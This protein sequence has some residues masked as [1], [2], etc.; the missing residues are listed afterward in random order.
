MVECKGERE[1]EREG[2]TEAES[3]RR[4]AI[5]PQFTMVFRRMKTACRATRVEIHMPCVYLMKMLRCVREF[6]NLLSE[7]ENDERE[8][9]QFRAAPQ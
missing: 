3:K 1:R 5:F 9:M 7:R 8:I 4:S 6:G 2:E